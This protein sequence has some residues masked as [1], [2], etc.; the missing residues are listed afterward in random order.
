MSLSFQ[1]TVFVGFIFTNL[2]I[3]NKC[4]SS[5]K[6]RQI[7]DGLFESLEA[8]QK[9]SEGIEKMPYDYLELNVPVMFT[10]IQVAK[11]IS[12]SK[13]QVFALIRSGELESLTIGRSRR[14]SQDQLIKYIMAKEKE[15]KK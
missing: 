5:Q 14:V 6:F 2:A 9:Q 11:I 7:S 8:H 10:P 1:L 13:S 15:K 4:S 3:Q 12:V